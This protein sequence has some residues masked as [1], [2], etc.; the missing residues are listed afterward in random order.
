MTID[1][2]YLK[3]SFIKELY[4][5][6]NQQV[7]D[8]PHC[9]P[10]SLEEFENG[11]RFKKFTSQ[12]HTELQS[13]AIIAVK[14]NEE[15]LGFADIAVAEFEQDGEVRKEGL[16]RFLAYQ[17]GHRSLGQAILDESERYLK[18]HGI[19]K[20]NAF[21]ISYP[22]DYC[23]SF[24]HLGFGLVSDRKWHLCALFLMNGY[25]IEGGEVFMH[26]PEYEVSLPEVPDN[27]VEIVVTRELGLGSLPNL[28][29]EALRDGNEIGVCHSLSAGQYCQAKEAQDWVFIKWLGVEESKQK[30]G[31]GRYLLQ[32]NLWEMK[33]IGYKN[34]IISTN[35]KNYR[36]QLF[37]TNYGYN[38]ADTTYQFVKNLD[39]MKSE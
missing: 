5:F 9:Y 13:E 36:A 17:P 30:Q 14:E 25:Q 4:S 6:Y 20:I 23:Y 34:T 29:V 22:K 35:I 16:I 8:I 10:V 27:K 28:T 19:N 33:K 26:W 11:F 12:P 39:K 37:Y 32:R 31:W 3:L 2:F 18:R 15:F 21:R 7:N 24:Y 1:I 38:I